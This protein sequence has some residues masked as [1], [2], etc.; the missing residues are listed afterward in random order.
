MSV[1]SLAVCHVRRQMSMVMLILSLSSGRQK[2][3]K[4]RLVGLGFGV[5]GGMS[6][7]VRGNSAR[8]YRRV[9]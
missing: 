8:R 3:E 6:E 1:L 9:V 4:R 5:A 2:E 7:G